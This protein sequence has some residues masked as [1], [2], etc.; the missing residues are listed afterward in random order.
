[1]QPHP[2]YPADL[3]LRGYVPNDLDATRLVVT[4]GSTCAVVFGIAYLVNDDLKFSDRL[5]VVWFVICECVLF[6]TLLR[7]L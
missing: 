5:I 4:F 1:M 3:I 2:Y 6:F 7:G